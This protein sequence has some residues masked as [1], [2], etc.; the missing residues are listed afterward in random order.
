MA[1]GRDGISLHKTA[2]SLPLWPSEV[3]CT[4][5]S[6]L[7]LSGGCG[8]KLS[9]TPCL[10]P[11]AVVT[12]TALWPPNSAG[13]WFSAICRAAGRGYRVPPCCRHG[14]SSL[15]GKEKEASGNH[16]HHSG[17]LAL[18]C[19]GSRC[20][21]GSLYLLCPGLGMAA[22]SLGLVPGTST[23]SLAPRYD[24]CFY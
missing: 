21:M 9:L 20:H 17:L 15:K 2:L 11:R 1:G 24:I 13:C 22:G 19:T 10:V 18:P 16:S 8:R 14:T 3:L 12:E 4:E 5:Q 23:I 7:L 6:D